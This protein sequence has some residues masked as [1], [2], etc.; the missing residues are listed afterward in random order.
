MG[1]LEEA[2]SAFEQHI[3][4]TAPRTVGTT[5][6]YY[7]ERMHNYPRIEDRVTLQLGSPEKDLTAYE[8]IYGVPGELGIQKGGVVEVFVR[9]PHPLFYGELGGPA[10]C[11]VSVRPFRADT[12]GIIGFDEAIL[13]LMF[14]HF[15]NRLKI[16][17]SR[18][19]FR[20]FLG[21]NVAPIPPEDVMYS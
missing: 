6:V 12:F 16:W 5:S 8:D 15:N 14:N 3:Y 7:V 9:T 1:L 21:A 11:L 20:K 10:I 18:A 2:K 19:F 17:D 13:E 4:W